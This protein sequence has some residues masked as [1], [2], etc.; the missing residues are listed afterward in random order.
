MHNYMS[1]PSPFQGFQARAN[2]ARWQQCGIRTTLDREE[3]L[4]RILDYKTSSSR[5]RTYNPSTRTSYQEVSKYQETPEYQE[6]RPIP[7]YPTKPLKPKKSRHKPRHIT[8]STSVLLNRS[9]GIVDKTGND[10]VD[11]LPLFGSK[12][13]NESLEKSLSNRIPSSLSQSSSSSVPYLSPS[14]IELIEAY[15]RGEVSSIVDNVMQN[16]RKYLG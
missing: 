12:A 7:S 11:S 3:A 6:D 4:K 9:K 13:F 15:G 2:Q 5:P 16:P 8:H 14:M 10:A 1:R